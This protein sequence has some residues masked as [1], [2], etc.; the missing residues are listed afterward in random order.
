MSSDSNVTYKMLPTKFS[1]TN[2]V[3]YIYI[4]IYTY[5]YIYVKTGFGV[6]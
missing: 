1:F 6:K 4:Y 3:I 5:I 2:Q